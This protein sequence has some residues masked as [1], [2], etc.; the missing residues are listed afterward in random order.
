MTL[1]ATS[2]VAPTARFTAAYPTYKATSQSTATLEGQPHN[3]I[4]KEDGRMAN[5]LRGKKVAILVPD[6]FGPKP[7]LFEV[8]ENLIPDEAVEQDRQNQAPF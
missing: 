6:G 7:A 2:N 5:T 3:I 1:R 4:Q 8:C